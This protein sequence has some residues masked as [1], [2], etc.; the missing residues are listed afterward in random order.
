MSWGTRSRRDVRRR[1]RSTGYWAIQH[2]GPAPA[3]APASCRSRPNEGQSPKELPGV[4]TSAWCV[5]R[6]ASMKGSP[7]RNCQ[8]R[9]LRLINR[10]HPASMKGS[11]RSNCQL[12]GGVDV[13]A[14]VGRASMKGSSRKNCKRVGLGE[15]VLGGGASMKGSSR[16]NCKIAVGAEALPKTPPQ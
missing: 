5:R 10:G 9:D 6:H 15:E 16:K 4:V 11:P 1:P 2:A 7:R 13:L 12:G 8:R 3:S 14:H